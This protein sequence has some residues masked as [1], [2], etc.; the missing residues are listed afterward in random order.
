[1]PAKFSV[2]D[3]KA[4]AARRP[5]GFVDALLSLGKIEGDIVHLD[6][7][8]IN[9]LRAQFPDPRPRNLERSPMAERTRAPGLFHLK[10]LKA[11]A[12][13]RPKGFVDFILARGKVEGGFIY[14]DEAA[15]NELDQKFFSPPVRPPPAQG[16]YLLANIKAAAAQ[17]PPGYLDFILAHGRIDGDTVILD[18]S[19]LKEIREKFPA[20]PPPP[21]LPEPT[22]TEMAINF[23]QAMAGWVKAG[24]K[25]VGRE[26]Y[27][28]RHVICLSCEYWDAQARAGQGKC[29]R[30]GCSRAKLWLAPSKCP[31]KP[32]KW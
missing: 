10:E 20:P 2:P 32:P 1:M 4:T 19:T 17:R 13:Q 23:T 25:V 30:C 7:L 29:R 22:V 6:D 26:V 14:L 18:E 12:K 3:L 31:L 9:K 21:R 24:F 27:E 11:S 15:Q 16:R 8:A 5:I 28:Q